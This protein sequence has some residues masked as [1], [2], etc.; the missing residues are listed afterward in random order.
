M[1]KKFT[2]LQFLVSISKLKFSHSEKLD[3]DDYSSHTHT[4]FLNIKN[5]FKN[6][7]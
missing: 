3:E 4:H 5:I 2:H 6:I 7:I 1:S